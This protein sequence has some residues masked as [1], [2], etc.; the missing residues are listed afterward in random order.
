MDDC[1]F[2]RIARGEIPCAKVFEDDETLAFMDL[3]P[4]VK[5]HVLV[6]PK[7]H[8]ATLADV[9]EETLARVH[10]TVKRVAA[11]QTKALGAQGV[12]VLQNNGAA[13]G[14]E[15][16]HLHVHVIPRFENDGHR[17]NWNPKSYESNEEMGALA[18]RIGAAL[19]AQTERTA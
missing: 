8:Y 10:A 7:T 4:I 1:I 14:Q 11:A 17:W 9:P 16:P 18:E 19:G 15:V 5:G 6:V 2:C 12:N 13:A 3:G